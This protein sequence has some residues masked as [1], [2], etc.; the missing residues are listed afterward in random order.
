MLYLSNLS[1]KF[2]Q[3]FILMSSNSF[4]LWKNSFSQTLPEEDMANFHSPNLPFGFC[5]HFQPTILHASCCKVSFPMP[6]YDHSYAH[7]SW[8]NCDHSNLMESHWH[9][10]LFLAQEQYLSIAQ[11]QVGWKSIVNHVRN[12]GNRCSDEKG[13]IS[14]YDDSQLL[15]LLS[16]RLQLI[17]TWLVE[18]WDDCEHSLL[19]KHNGKSV[20]IIESMITAA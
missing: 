18:L 2:S 8:C 10:A 17:N 14:F 9:R 4:S 6:Y 3:I 5:L 19:K 15:E 7:S 1:K 12:F 16:N 20:V 11:L 13:H